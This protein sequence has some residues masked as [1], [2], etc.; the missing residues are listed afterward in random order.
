MFSQCFFVSSLFQLFI[1]GSWY[2]YSLFKNKTSIDWLSQE[3]DQLTS[4]IT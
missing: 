1:Q 2:L 4:I 3:L